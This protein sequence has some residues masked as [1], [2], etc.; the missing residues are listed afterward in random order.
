MSEVHASSST[1]VNGPFQTKQNHSLPGNI[2]K[3]AR[4]SLEGAGVYFSTTA[5][6]DATVRTRY[7]DG[8]RRLSGLVQEEVNSGRITVAE[9]AEFCQS[10]RNQ[11][12]EETRKVTS[13]W[14]LASAQNLKGHGIGLETVLDRYSNRLFSKPFRGLTD[15]EKDQAYYAVIE[16]AGRSNATVNAKTAR[17]RTGGKVGILMTGALAAYS[18][19]SADDRVTETARQGTAIE[20]GMI[21]GTLAGL[22]VSTICGPAAPFCAIAVLLIGSSAGAWV[23]GATYDLYLDEVREFQTWRIR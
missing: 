14:G 6:S 22:A 1:V 4:D 15:A 16:A 8:I 13:P 21:G 10:M 12:M 11:I 23:T 2:L 19:A 7:A 18:I 9:G 17:L 3:D 5:I 20:G